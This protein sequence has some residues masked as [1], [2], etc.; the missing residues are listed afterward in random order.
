MTNSGG[1]QRSHD[2]SMPQKITFAL[3]HSGIVAL[4]IWLAFGGLEWADPLRARILA[5]CAILYFLRHLVTLFVL[6]KRQLAYSEVFGLS[7]FMAIFEIGFLILGAGILSNEVTSFVIFDWVGI[8]L[9]LFGSCLNTVSEL[10]RW[11]WKKRPSSKG[12][13]Y[14]EGL[15]GYSLHINYFGDTVL[16]SGWA[17]LAASIFSWA[18]PIF[19]TAGFV[20]I[21]I[22]PLDIYL[23]ERYGSE[24]KE[25]AKRTAKFIPF[26]Y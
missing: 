13:C 26:L 16:F 15:F 22:P 19:V 7:V 5:F 12:R 2:R 11:A 24:F 17:I 1:V 6:L 10:Q 25:Y 14:T 3:I 9:L 18:V 23:A 8:G 21:H 4:C 20:F